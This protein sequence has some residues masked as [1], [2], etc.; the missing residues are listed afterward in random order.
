MA[1]DT[2][3]DGIDDEHQVNKYTTINQCQN[4]PINCVC[5]KPHVEGEFVIECDKCKEWYHGICV[6]I[7]EKNSDYI[8][9]YYCQECF[10]EN[11]MELDELKIKIEELTEIAAKKETIIEDRLDKIEQLKND[12]KFMR[13]EVKE[14]DEEINEL[15][16]DIENKEK[17][18]KMHEGENKYNLKKIKQYEMKIQEF[19]NEKVLLIN[20][21]NKEMNG[22][23][24]VDN[25]CLNSLA[26]DYYEFKK[27]TLDKFS[28]LMKDNYAEDL[29]KT[30]E[31]TEYKYKL[32]ILEEK[33]KSLEEIIR[34]KDN[35]LDILV[36]KHSNTDNN[37]GWENVNVRNKQTYRENQQQCREKEKKNNYNIQVHNRFDGFPIDDNIDTDTIQNI[38]KNTNTNI[39]TNQYSNNHGN[40]ISRRPN[41]VIN[42]S[43]EY[44][45]IEYGTK[46]VPGN[47]SYARITS[48]GK[49]IHIYGD[50]LIKRLKGK[51]MA[52][53]IKI[54]NKTFI[55]SFPG[56]TTT[57]LNEYV[58]PTLREEQPDI[59]VINAGCND[60]VRDTK[61]AK[62]IAKNII[63]IGNTCRQEGIN[64]IFISSLII[65]NKF[66]SAKLIGE[67]NIVLRQL[68]EEYN[69]KYIDNINIL[70]CDLWE[71]GLHLL[72]DG[73]T[74]LGNNFINAINYNLC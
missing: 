35:D 44:D 28:K 69:F 30:K 14:K 40:N 66:K 55:R 27:Y 46:T 31:M 58:K 25:N 67:I 33:N 74:K 57:Y 52:R 62:E 64:E 73:L 6:G 56:S 43:P 19:D 2:T 38:K 42:E 50:S 18:I 8:E 34:G 61:S 47:G 11:D 72:D 39:V 20:E 60:V 71:D 21:K 26:Q 23:I 15:K 51:E 7:V 70:K 13:I 10:R 59:V 65:Q 5:L 45:I 1:D 16:L 4:I 37:C 36:C 3:N 48:K 53:F 68:C 63:G 22:N 24:D 29:T 12:L 32:N 54:N 17:N 49:R 41:P 9:I